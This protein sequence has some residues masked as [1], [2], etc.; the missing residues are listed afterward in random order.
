MIYFT[1]MSISI[2]NDCSKVAEADMAKLCKFLMIVL[3][4]GFGVLICSGAYN[5]K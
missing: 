3:I 1:S 4:F 5:N 2:S